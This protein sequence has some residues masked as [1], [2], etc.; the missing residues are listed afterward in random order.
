VAGILASLVAMAFVL[1]VTPGPNNVL[2]TAS[3]ATS[4]YLRTLPA[5]AGILAGFL[6]QIGLC[7]LGVGAAL[8]G[9]PALRVGFAVVASAY[10][11]WLALRLWRVHTTASYDV[12]SP[13]VGTWWRWSVLQFVN[14][15]TWLA[16]VTFVSG[17]LE[18]ARVTSLGSRALVTAVFLGVISTSMTIWTVFGTALRSRLGPGD[19]R[20]VSRSLAV[21]AVATVATFWI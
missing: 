6:V 3:G 12:S 10:M 18:S 19:W 7:A 11:V 2:L 9:E 4:G 13:V 16:N 20:V 8:A 1:S 21:L 15:K 5:Q 17:Y 14:P